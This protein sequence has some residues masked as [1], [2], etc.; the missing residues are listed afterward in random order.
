MANQSRPDRASR[1]KKSKAAKSKSEIIPN[2]F[3]FSET[4][5]INDWV[6]LL[7]DPNN[8]PFGLKAKHLIQFNVEN[9]NPD[10]TYIETV[11]NDPLLAKSLLRT[12]NDI[13]LS[14]AEVILSSIQRAIIL[15][16]IH[17]VRNIA[18]L[19]TIVYKMLNYNQ[20]ETLLKEI[21]HMY[22]AGILSALILQKKINTSNSEKI[23]TITT[24]HSIGKILYLVFSG[25]HSQLLLD[26]LSQPKHSEQEEIE[27]I[28][29][30]T[31]ELSKKLI[32]KWRLTQQKFSYE[33]KVDIHEVARMSEDLIAALYHGW[34]SPF[35]KAALV[36]IQAYL[37]FT[38][39]E[40]N[41]LCMETLQRALELLVF[42]KVEKLMDKIPLPYMPQDESEL[43]PENL[44][45]TENKPD[46]DK[47]KLTAETI[48]KLRKN[49]FKS[50]LNEVAVAALE[51]IYNSLHFD[52]VAFA[53][54]TPDREFLKVKTV[55]E[56]TSTDILA[57]FH[58]E[59]QSS[60]GWL[61]QHI[62]REQ[63]SAWVGAKSELV[64]GRLRTVE[65]NTKIGNG[66][67]FAFPL[68]VD[69]KAIGLYYADR[70][71]S[72]TRLDITSYNAFI[73]LCNATNETLQKLAN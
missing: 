36:P 41:S 66:Q 16:G 57:T 20:T 22:S 18:L 17:S 65:I 21:A 2:P 12:C 34:D 10:Y 5:D 33:E 11:L 73:E 6:A 71:I 37:G 4:K 51:S 15:L 63:R 58:F 29:F 3:D 1:T 14:P 46:A 25:A 60:E 26:L 23:F 72:H 47:I 45:L 56:R 39:R 27:A 62:L 59:L 69:G 9:K 44:A 28:G 55:F 43:I 31:S 64:L 54:L 7:N 24:W 32:Q 48:K 42:F 52:R 49:K 35:A 8:P 38:E 68:I 30:T 53:M 61:F 40:A 70:R 13:Y 50:D 19:T 67:F